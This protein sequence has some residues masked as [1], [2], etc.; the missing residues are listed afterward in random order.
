MIVTTHMAKSGASLKKRN[1]TATA[2]TTI[3]NE[4]TSMLQKKRP[5]R[6]LKMLN[7]WMTISMTLKHEIAKN[8]AI[9][10]AT[11]SDTEMGPVSPAMAQ[12]PVL[13]ARVEP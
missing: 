12:S 5:L 8:P 13:K 2:C 10:I 1:K 7:M 3:P 9:T 11:G 4:A 6:R